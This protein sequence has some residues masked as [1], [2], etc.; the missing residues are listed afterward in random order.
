LS[1]TETEVVRP[2]LDEEVKDIIAQK[3]AED[4]R[5]SLDTTCWLFGGA[6]PKFAADWRI[7]ITKSKTPGAESFPEDEQ[8]TF[9][10]GVTHPHEIHEGIER[11][12]MA[13][14]EFKDPQTITVEGKIPFT[15]PNVLRKAHRLPIPTVVKREDGSTEQ[16]AVIFKRT[17][18]TRYNP[19]EA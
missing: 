8:E 6:T 5:A 12:V 14:G 1:D 17:K 19:T 9:V 3:I 11:P 7:N 18:S 4:V 13:G 15:P 10:T 2:L 16:K